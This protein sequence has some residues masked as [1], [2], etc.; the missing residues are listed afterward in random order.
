[1]SCRAT[2]QCNDG[3]FFTALQF[4]E[5]KSNSYI[6]HQLN[7]LEP[8]VQEHWRLSWPYY[9]SP[10][11]TK[12][13]LQRIHGFNRVRGRKEKKEKR[14]GKGKGAYARMQE[15]EEARIEREWS[16]S[17]RGNNARDWHESCNPS[18]QGNT[19]PLLLLLAIAPPCFTTKHQTLNCSP[20]LFLL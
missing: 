17:V 1:M 9:Y 4:T 2:K 14:G 20:E 10:N 16:T 8:R 15:E 6:M 13:F 3:A 19:P 12:Q 11:I 7:F 18:S 5:V